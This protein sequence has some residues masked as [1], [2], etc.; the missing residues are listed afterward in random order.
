MAGD[1]TIACCMLAAALGCSAMAHAD[2]R[3]PASA[4]EMVVT[5]SPDEHKSCSELYSEFRSLYERTHSQHPS[6]WDNPLNTVAAAVGTVFPPA[7]LVWGYSAYES[8]VDHRSAASAQ[9]RMA[10]LRDV[11]ARKQCFVR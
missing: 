2:P 7:Y 6:V 4:P 3:T 1:A 11:S 8:F 9:A 10:A 5:A